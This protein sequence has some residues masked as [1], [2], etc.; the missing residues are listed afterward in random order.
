M[1]RSQRPRAW[2]PS[3][4]TSSSCRRLREPTVRGRGGSQP[5]SLDGCSV[6]PTRPPPPSKWRSWQ[7]E[8]TVRTRPRP[9][10]GQNAA[11]PAF[12]RR[13]S[14]N[15]GQLVP[16]NFRLWVSGSGRHDR[17]RS[18][19]KRRAPGCPVG[20]GST[21]PPRQRWWCWR[22]WGKAAASLKTAAKSRVV[23]LAIL[24]QGRHPAQ[25]RHSRVGGG[26]SPAGRRLATRSERRGRGRGFE[27]SFRPSS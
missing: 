24:G 9:V 18:F 27:G 7:V 13:S 26:H 1:A 11:G 10:D 12:S 2:P 5:F 15:P 19:G 21:P 23:V 22:S 17:T 8:A 25:H 4:S 16:T 14:T 20:A 3:S 6:R